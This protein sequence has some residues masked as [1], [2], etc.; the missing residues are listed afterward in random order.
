MSKKVKF[1][2]IPKKVKITVFIGKI[3]FIDPL[4][5]LEDE[6]ASEQGVRIVSGPSKAICVVGERL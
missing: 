1:F 5:P 2:G 4:E 6:L 3:D